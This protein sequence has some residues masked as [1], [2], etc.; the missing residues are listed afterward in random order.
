MDDKQL[1]QRILGLPLERVEYLHTECG[2]PFDDEGF[3]QWFIANAAL[4]LEEK[5]RYLDS[6]LF[7]GKLR[8]EFAE[9]SA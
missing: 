2:M 7:P 3:T 5:R 9:T 6:V 8:P 4:V 1:T